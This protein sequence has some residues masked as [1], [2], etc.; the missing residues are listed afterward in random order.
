M[1]DDSKT[2][3]FGLKETIFR[4]RKA[5]LL[6]TKTNCF[7]VMMVYDAF[8]RRVILNNKLVINNLAPIMMLL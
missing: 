6:Q 1:S 7:A 5:I 8:T 4:T 2:I 3:C